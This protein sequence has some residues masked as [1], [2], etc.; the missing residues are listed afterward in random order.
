MIKVLW[1]SGNSALYANRNSSYNGGG[2]IYTL[3]KQILCG[4]N[5][6]L[7]LAFPWN[8]DVED[9]DTNCTYYG[10][11]KPHL[12]LFNKTYKEKTIKNRISEILSKTK[13]DIIHVWGTEE[14][15]G[16]VCDI[17]D[18]PVVIHIQGI[19]GPIY[20]AW[21]PNGMSW[22]KL[23]FL[24]PKN[25][26][27]RAVYKYFVKRETLIMQKCGYFI[28][29]TNWDK[30]ISKF[31]SPKSTYFYCSE[32]LRS[33]IYNSPKIWKYKKNRKTRTIISIISSGLYKG[34]DVILKVAKLLNTYSDTFYEWHIYGISTL[35]DIERIT[36]INSRDV[37]VMPMGVIN[38]SQLIDKI[39]DADL[40]AHFSYIENSS[41]A[42]CEAQLLGIPI[43]ATNVG[44]MSSLIK[45]NVDGILAPSNDPYVL[46]SIINSLVSDEETSMSLG[47]EGRKVALTR[48]NPDKIT[49]DI[50]SIYN[51]IIIK[52]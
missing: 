21:L 1:L 42:V 50:L 16:L 40:F 15:L 36:H 14:F 46:S 7:S 18:I 41:N 23:F 13:P 35:K 17:T 44:G 3:Q 2:W 6:K 12:Y 10:I 27:I 49:N 32:M 9:F 25:M 4:G 31:I 28:G 51:S 45:N 29:R 38:A 11:K 47:C 39:A 19:L 22:L 37:N 5:I 43:V 34:A 30:S 20:N 33:E 52:K 8:E 24:S 26:Y 48:H